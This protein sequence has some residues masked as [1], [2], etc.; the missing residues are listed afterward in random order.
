MARAICSAALETRSA[1]LRLPIARK[2]VFAK[3]GPRIGLGYRR[4][5]TAG[6]WV[7]RIADGKGGNTL[8]A[9]GT[10]DDFTEADGSTILTLWQAQER[11]RSMAAGNVARTDAITTVAMALDRYAA[12]LRTRGADP[13]NVAR[14]RRHLPD[15]LARKPVTT[16]TARDLRGWRDKL[17]LAPASINRTCSVLKAALN[18]IADQD[19][20][21]T[22]RRAWETGLASLPDAEESRNVILTDDQVRALIAEAYHYSLEFGLLVETA[23]VTGARVSQLAKLTVDDLQTGAAPRLM[24]PSSKKGRG[25]KTVLR[26]PVPIRATLAAKLSN[27]HEGTLLRKPT[28]APWSKSDHSRPFA[29]AARLCGLG[30][31]VTIY[32]LRHSNIVRQLL[33]NVPV[34]VV[35]VN[36]DTSVAMIERTYSRH[37]AD[38]ADTLARGALL[39]F[40]GRAGTD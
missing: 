29:R 28:G 10:A 7:L 38:H 34:R 5:R 37:I 31:E 12:D 32:A 11:A 30:S 19:D 3:L 8:K 16:L 20:S 21:I 2:P 23:A 26:R 18:L 1:R 24:I 15:T 39:A 27:S 14:V 35:A 9:I 40:D 22:S 17:P 4:N 6:T 33:A 36:H 25:R 13:G